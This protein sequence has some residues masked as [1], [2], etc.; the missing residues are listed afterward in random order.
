MHKDA[1]EQV[2]VL[3]HTSRLLPFLTSNSR[4]VT[5]WVDPKTHVSRSNHQKAAQ[6]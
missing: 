6:K 5:I 4:V 1:R 3:R 2:H